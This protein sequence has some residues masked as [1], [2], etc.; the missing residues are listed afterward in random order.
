MKPAT[1]Y[2]NT[3]IQQLDT[4]EYAVWFKVGDPPTVFKTLKEAMQAIDKIKGKPR[5]EL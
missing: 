4:G 1:L 2:R 3:L 5:G